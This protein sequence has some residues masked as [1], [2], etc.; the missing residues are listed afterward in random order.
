M[1]LV[2]RHGHRIAV[3]P[4]IHNMHCMVKIIGICLHKWLD[5]ICHWDFC[6]TSLQLVLIIMLAGA[7][8]SKWS[9]LCRLGR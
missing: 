6:D 3:T 8:P 4:C 2:S 5:D 7:P 9:I 1:Q